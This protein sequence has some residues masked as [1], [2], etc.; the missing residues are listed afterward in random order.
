VAGGVFGGASPGGGL[1]SIAGTV[2]G[3]LL[4]GVLNIGLVLLDVS[5]YW[6]Q[7]IKGLVILAA[8]AIDRATAGRSSSSGSSA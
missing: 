3:C 8:V 5:P 2:L 7:V 6:Q 4:I 1:G